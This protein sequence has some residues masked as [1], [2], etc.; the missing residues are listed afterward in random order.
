MNEKFKIALFRKNILTYPDDSKGEN[1]FEVLYALGELLNLRIVSGDKTKLTQ[2]VLA[3]AQSSVGIYVAPAFYKRFPWSVR[4]LNQKE[5]LFD[6]LNHYATTYGTGDFSTPGHS[7]FEQEYERAPFN[8]KIKPKKFRLMSESEGAKIVLADAEAMLK[9]TRPLSDTDFD[10]LKAAICDYGL[11][12]KTVASKNT[13]IRL[14]LAFRMTRYVGMLNLSDIL[15]VVDELMYVWYPGPYVQ[16]Q[17]KGKNPLTNLHLRNQDRKWITALIDRKFEQ[18]G[19]TL[20]VTECFERKALWAGLL[21]HL[22]YKPKNSTARAFVNAMRGNKNYSTYAAMEEALKKNGATTAL[23]VL[24]H[25]KGSGSVLRS[26]NY[27]LSRCKSDA[28]IDRVLSE[29]DTATNQV[30]L[31]QLLYAYDLMVRNGTIKPRVF[32]FTKHNLMATHTEEQKEWLARKSF[33]TQKLAERARDKV[34]ARLKTLWKD[35]FGKVYIDPKMKQIAWPISENATD[36]GIGVLPK[37]SKFPLDMSKTLRAFTYWEKVDDID[38][39]CVGM[40]EDGKSV[41]FSWRTMSSLQSEAITFSGDQTSGFDGGSE[42]FDIDVEMF[43]EQ[44]PDVRYVIFSDN[45]YSMVPFSGV[46]CRAGYMLRSEPNSGEIFEPKTVESSFTIN[47]ATTFVHLFGID[48]KEGTFV[49]LNTASGI[50]TAIAGEQSQWF[51]VDYFSRTDTFT[52]YDFFAWSA[53]EIIDDPAL[54]DVVVSDDPEICEGKESYH[55]YDFSR[56]AAL[57]S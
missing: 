5:L 44:W 4:E 32:R 12:A 16:A 37:G 8:E 3:F 27:L 51:L 33:L 34:I 15:K 20:N 22:H 9:Q 29:F 50:Q 19:P 35:R 54:A 13:A 21:H 42:Y 48:M 31:V 1:W 53:T 46:L 17:S 30:I 55:S 40:T 45:V 23:E 38:L 18:G 39:S 41:E 28:E 14:M 25:G 11:N 7:I 47:S 56:L 6:Q 26:M 43:R 52:V 57:L 2:D 49:W 10:I 24:R 36:A